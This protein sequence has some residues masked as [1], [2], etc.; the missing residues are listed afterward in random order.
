MEQAADDKR[1]RRAIERTRDNRQ[2]QINNQPGGD[3]AVKANAVLALN[4]VLHRHLDHGGGRKVGCNGRAGV[5]NRQ[6]WQRQSGNNQ[7]K[8]T[9]ASGGDD[10]HGGGGGQRRSMAISSKKPKAKA[11]VVALPTPLLSS[12]ASGSGQVAVAAA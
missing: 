7:L 2:Q 1:E 8:V 9:V 5:D 6:Q 12:L 3:T 10:S 4:G 11:I